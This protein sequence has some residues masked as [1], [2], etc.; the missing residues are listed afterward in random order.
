MKMIVMLIVKN[1]LIYKNNSILLRLPDHGTE[2]LCTKSS[3]T[4][5]SSTRRFILSILYPN[6]ARS[7]I[8]LNFFSKKLFLLIIILLW[9][10]Y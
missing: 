5:S 8:S 4:Y 2:L 6:D 1:Y 9:I 7:R 3:K 10:L